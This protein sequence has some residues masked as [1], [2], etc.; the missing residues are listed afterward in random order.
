MTLGD[1]RD[2]WINYQAP[3][4][5]LRCNLIGVITSLLAL[6]LW[7]EVRRKHIDKCSGRDYVT[8]LTGGE[9][10]EADLKRETRHNARP[11]SFS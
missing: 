3:L 8:I 7:L 6:C 1:F 9:R 4:S 11:G 5:S 10:G 2:N